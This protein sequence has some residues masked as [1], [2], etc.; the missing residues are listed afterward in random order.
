MDK[1]KIQVGDIERGGKR[2]KQEE[3]HDHKEEG[4]REKRVVRRTNTSSKLQ[5]EQHI[6]SNKPYHIQI[7]LESYHRNKTSTE[8]MKVNEEVKILEFPQLQLLHAPCLF[9]PIQLVP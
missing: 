5:A 9:G 6:L 4:E 1:N 2:R 7:E 3:K 8:K